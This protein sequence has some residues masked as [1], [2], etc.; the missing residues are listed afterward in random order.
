MKQVVFAVLLLAVASLTGCLTDNTSVDEKESTDEGTSN[1]EPVGENNLTNL[2]KRISELEKE[3]D[4]LEKNLVELRKDLDNK[5]SSDGTVNSIP[6]A[7]IDFPETDTS[8]T[9]ADDSFELIGTGYDSDGIV[10]AYEWASDIDGVISDKNNVS[11]PTL[12][13]GNHVITFRTMDDN[14]A[15]SEPESFNLEMMNYL[16]PTGSMIAYEDGS[17]EWTVQI[18]KIN[19][20]ISIN[21]VS[22]VL[23]DA[24]NLFVIGGSVLE[25]N[26]S[27]Q[28][29]SFDDMDNSERISP[30]DKF[31]L[32]P[33]EGNL[34]DFSSLQDY[35][36][37]IKY[38]PTEE[39][40][41]YTIT[42]TS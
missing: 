14:G 34:S 32:K 16:C 30:G 35:G 38:K 26:S 7:R 31:I 18:V 28:G 39:F 11:N 20:L 41:G 17:G 40:I 29:I 9:C 2:E 21:N 37:S 12:T 25:L 42:L 3:V 19:P 5:L 4:N 36:F 8:I 27:S 1:I 22:W 10:W 15:W 33:G 6:L 13:A 23:T 24:N